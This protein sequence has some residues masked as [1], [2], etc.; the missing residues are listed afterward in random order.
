MD[1]ALVARKAEAVETQRGPRP[2]G[3]G[4]VLLAE[5]QEQKDFLQNAVMASLAAEQRR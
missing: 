5:T 1:N 3:L 4:V 2:R